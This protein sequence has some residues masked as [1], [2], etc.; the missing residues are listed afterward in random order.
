MMQTIKMVSFRVKSDDGYRISVDSDRDMCWLYLR[1][2]HNS[3]IT[4]DLHELEGII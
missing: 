2:R 1:G 3:S 4:M